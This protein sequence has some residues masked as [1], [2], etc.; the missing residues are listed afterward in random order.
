M[1][2]E[3][4][5][6]RLLEEILLIDSE[7]ESE[8]EQ[9]ESFVIVLNGTVSEGVIFLVIDLNLFPYFDFSSQTVKLLW[10]SFVSWKLRRST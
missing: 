3:S 7:S 9:E 2:K 8:G 10:M 1:S 4:G 6:E 5:K